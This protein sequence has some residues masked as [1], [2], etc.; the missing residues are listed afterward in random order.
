M[1]S[2]VPPG[3]ASTFLGLDLLADLRRDIPGFCAAQKA[4]HGDAVHY[5]IGPFHAFHFTHPDQ[6][7]EVLVTHH[8]SFHKP[9]NL[10]KVLGQ[11]D[12][13]GLVL[14][15]GDFW[16]R[17]RRLIQPAFKPQR[18]EGHVAAVAARVGRMLDGWE[19]QGEVQV[20]RDLARLTLGVVAEA[21]F[22]AD[23]ER[24]TESFIEAVAVLNEIA[25]RELQLPFVL[26]M[27]APTPSKRRLRRAVTTIHGI[28]EG[29][30]AE[31]R[32]EGGRGD[33]GDLL[34]AL[35]LAVDEE[36]G[37][38]MTDE[39]ARDEAVNLFLG[40]NETTATAL[41]WAAYVLAK[42]P[43]VQEDLRREVDAVLGGRAPG[44]ADLAALP[45]VERAFK[46]AMR[47][48]PPAYIFGREA[49]EDVTIGGYLVPRGS[50][51]NVVPFVTHRDPRWFPDPEAFRPSR[52]A[53]EA[54]IP[55]GAYL[56]FGLG[57][58]A[59]IGR[60]FAMQEAVVA[61]AM[62]L[63]RYVLS[64]PEGAPDV[65]MEAQVSLHPRGGLRLGVARRPR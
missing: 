8:R 55:R 29:L 47:L 32:A 34:S 42:H 10:K 11:W 53:D 5:R 1:T 23:V 64:I 20:D 49:I 19:G 60:A 30:I 40:G 62:L 14:S 52:F 48:Y 33:R 31:R 2:P 50:L 21:L 26:P 7:V 35:L 22:G 51:V 13:N 9:F 12:G 15:E 28:V 39:Q 58:R 65:E 25:I 54:S 59:C 27:W 46:E 16:V 57:P 43:D 41:T 24:H 56:P 63:G 45:R 44:A 6:V 61:L 3:P 37:G 38:G 17:Q 36:G 18:L 4:A